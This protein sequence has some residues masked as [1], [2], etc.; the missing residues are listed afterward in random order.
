MLQ[1]IRVEIWWI[2]LENE[3][4]IL[5][6][7]FQW[8]ASAEWLWFGAGVEK[9]LYQIYLIFLAELPFRELLSG[10]YLTQAGIQ[11]LSLMDRLVGLGERLAEC[12]ESLSS[13]AL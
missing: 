8:L 4:L 1:G 2:P 5:E 10:M 13:L 3:G 9:V 12:Q 7:A 11:H 6:V